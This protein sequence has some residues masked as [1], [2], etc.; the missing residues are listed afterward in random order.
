MS[1]VTEITPRWASGVS[2]APKVLRRALRKMSPDEQSGLVARNKAECE[3]LQAR[4]DLL[5]HEN[6]CIRDLPRVEALEKSCRDQRLR[7]TKN[8]VARQQDTVARIARGETMQQI[9]NA[10]FYHDGDYARQAFGCSHGTAYPPHLS[11]E[12]RNVLRWATA[13]FQREFSEA[14]I[15][16]F[17]ANRPAMIDVDGE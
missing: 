13:R 8:L 4:V 2:A 14:E 9:V 15:E 16:V 6:K 5:A 1:Y 3:R 10:D 11:Y 12:H 17:I 7:A